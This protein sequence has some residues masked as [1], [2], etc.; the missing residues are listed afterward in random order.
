MNDNTP[1]IL[2]LDISS[3]HI[4]FVLY[5]GTGASDTPDG[6]L[7]HAEWT[8]AGDI[9]A[10]CKLAYN[11]FYRCL[12]R[13][14]HVDCLAIESPVLRYGGSIPQIRVSGAILTLAGQRGLPH[15]EVSPTEA[16]KALSGKGVCSKD[17]MMARASAYGVAGE[18]ASDALGV[19]LASVKQIQVVTG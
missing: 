6:V 5:H 8:L 15:V 17:T 7:D 9:S 3:T 11:H 13:Y 19:A 14:P 10:R 2:A 1:Y 16:K 18:H 4:G 12:E